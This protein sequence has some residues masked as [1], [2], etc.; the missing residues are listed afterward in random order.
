MAGPRADM[1]IHNTRP[2]E[3]ATAV[4][5][6]MFYTGLG[7]ARSLGERGIPVIG[8]SAHRRVYGNFSRYAR[9]LHCADSRSE[10]EALLKQLVALGKE[11][12]RR[13]VLFPTRDHDLVFVDRFRE[14]LEL[15]F[16]L[17][18]P[19][20]ESLERCLNKW[21]TYQA[22]VAA[23]VATPSSWLIRDAGEL[24][25]A[26][27]VVKYPCVLKPVAAHHWR[28]AGNWDVVGGRKAISVGSRDALIAEYTAIASAEQRALLQEQVPGADDALLIVACYVDR[29]SNFQA[30]FN[31]QKLVQTPVGFGTGCIV[32][33]TDRP[34]LLEPTIRLLREVNFTG[35]A[36]VEYKYDAAAGEYKL[37]EINPRPWDQHRIGA[38]CGVDLI[39]LA[40]CDHAGLPKPTVRTAFTARKWVAEDAF[41]MAAL[42]L[43]WRREWAVAD[44]FRQ[45]RGRKV[46][47]IWSARDP[48]PFVAYV[49]SLVPRLCGMAFQAIL[50]VPAAIAGSRHKVALRMTP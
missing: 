29:E 8:L 6:N 5:L 38:A 28:T 11:L 31:I 20:S 36:E 1:A 34:E 13:A 15:Y 46:Y 30:S 35:I 43:L 4:V 14:Q 9:T 10:P 12:N 21:D 37:I 32:Q 42:R 33:S 45:A 39:Y 17:V 18:A 25:Q 44:L 27:A 40:Y 48:L 3:V 26:A 2:A 41:V 7:I 47:A 24:R 22:A 19:S 50:R 49:V 16:E 23:K